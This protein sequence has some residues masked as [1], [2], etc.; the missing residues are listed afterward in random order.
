MTP[1]IVAFT[2]D[3]EP[4]CPPFLSG[5]RGIEQGLPPLL[6][7]LGRLGVHGTFFT[8]GEVAERYPEVPR[9]LIAAGHELACHGMTHRAFTSLSAE[10]ARRELSVSSEILR[11]HG[12][13][14]SFRAPYLRFPDA[15]VPLLEAHG[16]TLDSSQAIYKPAH[17]SR[18]RSRTSIARVPASVTSSVLRIPRLLREAYLSALS[19][20]VV[21]FVHPWE[22]VDLRRERIR[23]DCRFRTGAEALQ[24]VDAVVRFFLAQQATFVRMRELVPPTRFAPLPAPA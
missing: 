17:W 13:V 12:S 3:V 16:F 4:D 2:V 15:Y 7:L 6:D 1:R 8:T 9:T 24:C 5:Y 11:Q 10:E 14:T 18:A 20:P 19:T 21:L 22:F 23:Y